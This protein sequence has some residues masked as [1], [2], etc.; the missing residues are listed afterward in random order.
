MAHAFIAER[1]PVHAKSK[2][3]N[4]VPASAYTREERR[5]GKF[6]ETKTRGPGA[7]A[8]RYLKRLRRDGISPDIKHH[9]PGT[10]DG[11]PESWVTEFRWDNA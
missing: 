6:H 4:H 5:V 3:R 8:A 10:L 9:A 2:S 7:R 1:E 11:Y